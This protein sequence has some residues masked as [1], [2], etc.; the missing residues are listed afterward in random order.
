MFAFT[1]LYTIE[2]TLYLE[3]M[4]H[5]YWSIK[6]EV[7]ML[8]E[9]ERKYQVKSAIDQTYEDLAKRKVV[10]YGDITDRPYKT[11]KPFNNTKV[12]ETLKKIGFKNVNGSPTFGPFTTQRPKKTYFPLAYGWDLYE[13][14]SD[15]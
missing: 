13:W 6:H 8:H 10:N 12:L 2:V 1:E 9:I 7:Y 4:E 5:L 15:F 11:A 3:E 14:S